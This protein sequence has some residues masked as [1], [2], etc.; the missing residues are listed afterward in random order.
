MAKCQIKFINIWGLAVADAHVHAHKYSF[1]SLSFF[2][3]FDEKLFGQR[4][5]WPK[6][7]DLTNI[8]YVFGHWQIAF[9]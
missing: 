3:L 9:L 1:F 2:I 6:F 5:E 7:G 4:M 8:L